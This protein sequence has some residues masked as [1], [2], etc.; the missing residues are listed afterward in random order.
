MQN[1]V[2]AIKQNLLTVYHFS[3]KLVSKITENC[4]SKAQNATIRGGKLITAYTIGS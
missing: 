1:F 4:T 3:Q 2:P